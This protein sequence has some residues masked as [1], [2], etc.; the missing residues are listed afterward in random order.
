MIRYECTDKVTQ[1]MLDQIKRE[2]AEAQMI[3]G[4]WAGCSPFTTAIK[5]QKAFM[6]WGIPSMDNTMTM[7][8][9]LGLH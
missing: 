4:L 7:F 8:I 9:E 3:L 2:H 1:I 5:G 6:V